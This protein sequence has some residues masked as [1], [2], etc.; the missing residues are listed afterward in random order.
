MKLRGLLASILVLA[1]AQSA[2][3][4]LSVTSHQPRYGT[5]QKAGPCGL[6]DGLRTTDKVYIAKPGTQVTIEWN[7]TIDHPSTYRIDFDLDGDDDFKNPILPCID[8]TSIADCFDITNTGPYMVNNITDE[9]AA[10]QSYLYTLPNV[11]C[12][13]CTLQVIQTMHDKPPFTDPGNE[14]Y[15]QCVDIILDNNGPD[16]LTLVDAPPMADAGPGDADASP[17]GPGASDAGIVETKPIDG[18]CQTSGSSASGAL[19]LLLAALWMRK[20]RSA[21]LR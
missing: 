5:E 8:Q 3:A 2:H 9:P 17:V 19:L 13:N 7:E 1:F 15:Y 20:S 11:E 16:V 21:S 6:A 4:H 14:I 10:I 12:A 18:G